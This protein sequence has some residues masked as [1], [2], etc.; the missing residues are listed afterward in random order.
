MRLLYLLML[1]THFGIAP[2]IKM[3]GAVHLLPLYTFMAQTRTVS[4]FYI[5][6][7]AF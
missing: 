2:R 3:S 5:F 7:L 1:I 4:F 6:A